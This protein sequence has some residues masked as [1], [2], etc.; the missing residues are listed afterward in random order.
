MSHPDL[1][2]FS[3]PSA[4]WVVSAGEG[5]IVLPDADLLLS[6]SY[7]RAGPVLFIEGGGKKAVVVGYF[8]EENAAALFSESGAN[9]DG[10]TDRALAGDIRGGGRLPRWA[11]VVDLTRSAM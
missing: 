4:D 2:S 8:A 10:A 6:G 5:K 11:A 3:G 1:G 7:S 9:L